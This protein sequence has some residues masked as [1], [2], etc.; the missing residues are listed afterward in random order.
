[1]HFYAY[2][3]VHLYVLRVSLIIQLHFYILEFE[4]L[5]LISGL[6]GLYKINVK[7]NKQTYQIGL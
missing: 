4:N 1:M 6:D 3:N 2:S 5:K 7:L